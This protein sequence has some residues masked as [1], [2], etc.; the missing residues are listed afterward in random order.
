MRRSV[1]QW[2]PT[3]T[4]TAHGILGTKRQNG[5]I[6]YKFDGI[7]PGCANGE[8]MLWYLQNDKRLIYGIFLQLLNCFMSN[9]IHF[10]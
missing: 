9:G 6:W 7:R 4:D 8:I 2:G 5:Q 1:R 3:G 10:V